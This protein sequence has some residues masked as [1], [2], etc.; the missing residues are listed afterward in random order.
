MIYIL[1]YKIYNC[2]KKIFI[3][4]ISYSLFF[5]NHYIK[6]RTWIAN[7]LFTERI[8]S[9]MNHLCP[10]I[11]I[12]LSLPPSPALFFWIAFWVMCVYL[13]WAVP[14]L[15]RRISSQTDDRLMAVIDLDSRICWDLFCPGYRQPLHWR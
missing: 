8:I 14:S 2:L 13:T 5:K 1:I 15:T 9:S 6:F 12:T 10:F 4:Y 11:R 3:L 7:L